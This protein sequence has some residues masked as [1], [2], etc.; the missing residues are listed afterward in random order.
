MPYGPIPAR[1]VRQLAVKP[2]SDRRYSEAIELQDA[3]EIS[4]LHLD[5]GEDQSLILSLDPVEILPFL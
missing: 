3:F 1:P 4:G 5:S 2:S